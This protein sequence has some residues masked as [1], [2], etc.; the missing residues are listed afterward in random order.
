[1]VLILGKINHLDEFIIYAREQQTFS[2]GPDKNILSFLGYVFS[3]SYFLYLFLLQP[4]QNVK[5][6]LS[7]MAEVIKSQI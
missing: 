5:I 3:L 1:M 7:L 4:L 6:I 2:E